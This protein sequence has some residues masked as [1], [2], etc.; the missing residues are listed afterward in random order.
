MKELRIKCNYKKLGAWTGDL[1]ICSQMLYH[2]LPLTVIKFDYYKEE[3]Y[4]NG[5]VYSKNNVLKTILFSV[6]QIKLV[7]WV[8]Q[9]KQPL[10]SYLFALVVEPGSSSQMLEM[11]SSRT[12]WNTQKPNSDHSHMKA[13]TLA[14]FYFVCRVVKLDLRPV[15]QTSI[16]TK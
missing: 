4:S 13:W 16:L 1:S 3:E 9:S 14:W 12:W 6:V 2:Y 15:S 10:W 8:Q 7:W 5:K 11:S